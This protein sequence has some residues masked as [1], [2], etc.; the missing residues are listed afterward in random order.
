MCPD[1]P[2]P[3][4]WLS[5][6]YLL[7]ANGHPSSQL[8]VALYRPCVFGEIHSKLRH[9]ASLQTGDSSWSCTILWILIASSTTHIIRLL[10]QL[11]ASMWARTAPMLVKKNAILPLSSC[12]DKF[13]ETC[14]SFLLN[15]VWYSEILRR[16]L[17][18][19]ASSFRT[20]IAEWG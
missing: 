16:L 9:L 2:W 5:P 4:S 8:K 13:E 7:E 11:S 10:N 6:E 3:G 12:F 19:A 1:L 17:T 15:V 14:C 20:K 18:E